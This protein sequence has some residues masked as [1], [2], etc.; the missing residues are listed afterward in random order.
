MGSFVTLAIYGLGAYCLRLLYL[1]Y[2]SARRQPGL[3]PGPPT[4]PFIGNIHIFPTEQLQYKFTEWAKIYG[5]IYS[6]KVMHLTIIV[7][8]SPT[9]VRDIIDKRGPISSSRPASVMTEIVTPDSVNLGSAR[10]ANKTWRTLRRAAVHMLRPENMDGFMPLQR[11]EAAQ[12]MWELS[13]NPDSFYEDICR[14][15]TSFFMSVIYG[16][17]APRATCHAAREFS[18]TQEEFVASMEVGKA[19]PVDVFPVLNW[20]PR[21]FANWKRRAYRLRTRQEALFSYL[22]DIVAARIARGAHNGAFMEEAKSRADEWGLT[23]RLLLHLGGAL[24]EGSDTTASVVQGFVLILSA[25]PAVQ[26]YAHQE[27]DAVVGIDEPP[28]FDDLQRLPYMRAILD[29]Y[30]RFRPIAPLTLPHAMAEDDMY[31]GMLFPTDAIIFTNMWAITHDER[32]FDE[33]DKF[34]PERFMHDQFGIRPGVQDDPAR[35]ENL[36]FGGGRRICPG[37]YTAR[38]L[39]EINLANFI[40]AFEFSPGLDPCSG[41]AIPPDLWNYKNGISLA[42]EKFRATITV[43]SPEKKEIIRRHFVEQ[44]PILQPF[45]QDLHPEDLDFVRHTRK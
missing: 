5:D 9:A 3:P 25:Y 45:E 31:N 44:S 36:M 27:M 33:P 7:L 12:L 28:K 15:T 13:T 40:W 35:R 16:V 42:P 6:L 23:P 2:C 38:M 1:L 41:Q 11:A 32:Y 17:R 24:L 30:L 20:V 8:N 22:Q 34:I 39:L 10:H 18:E 37:A 4:W 19:P 14:F 29:E 21:R 43:R 26:K